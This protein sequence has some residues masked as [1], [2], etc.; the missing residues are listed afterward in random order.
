MSPGTICATGSPGPISAF[1]P[2]P[3]DFGGRRYPCP[4]PDRYIDGVLKGGEI[5]D[6]EELHPPS[7]SGGRVPDAWLRTAQ[8]IEEWE[9]RSA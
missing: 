8:G 3:P 7:G 9:Y 5:I 6:S 2:G 1:G 4:G